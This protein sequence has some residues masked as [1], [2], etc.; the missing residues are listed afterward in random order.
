MLTL[1]CWVPEIKALIVWDT[2]C[3]PEHL[4]DE[5]I[6]CRAKYLFA[7]LCQAVLVTD[8]FE[9]FKHWIQNRMNHS[10]E[11]FGCQMVRL[12]RPSATLRRRWLVDSLGSFYEVQN[13]ES[14][15]TE[16]LRL[17]DQCPRAVSPPWGRQAGCLSGRDDAGWFG[18][19]PFK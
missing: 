15:K 19:D 8:G 9:A 12:F 16:W 6:L 10:Y 5:H 17:V 4:K 3:E 14:E 7:L 2:D 1:W 18:G 11:S 13:P